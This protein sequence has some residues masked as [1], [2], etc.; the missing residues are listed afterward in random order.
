MKNCHCPPSCCQ[1]AV[2]TSLGETCLFQLHQVSGTVK[3]TLPADA[4]RPCVPL[5]MDN[6]LLKQG[7]VS[8]GK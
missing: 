5:L 1:G 6:L 2:A 7:T 4:G 3:S 8:E